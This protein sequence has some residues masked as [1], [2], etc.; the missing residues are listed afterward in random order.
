[1]FDEPMPFTLDGEFGGEHTEVEVETLE[2][3]ARIIIQKPDWVSLEDEPDFEGAP[4]EVE[5]K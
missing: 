5:E 2:H 1:M 3:A 4:K